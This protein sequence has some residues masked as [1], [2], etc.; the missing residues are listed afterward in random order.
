MENWL[1]KPL[2]IFPEDWDLQEKQEN[3]FP[4]R[5]LLERALENIEK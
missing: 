2:I 5:S 1:L 3:D 4:D